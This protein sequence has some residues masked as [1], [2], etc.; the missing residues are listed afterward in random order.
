MSSP[1]DRIAPFRKMATDDPTSE[2]AR[3]VPNFEAAFHT[4]NTY[5]VPLLVSAGEDGQLGLYEPNDVTNFGYL[6]QPEPSQFSGSSLSNNSTLFD[7]LTNQQAA[8]G[9]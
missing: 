4:P 7:N 6:A 3:V 9:D 5:H 2:I 8:S 1:E